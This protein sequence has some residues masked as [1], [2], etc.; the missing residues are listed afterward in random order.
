MGKMTKVIA[1][2]KIS[3]RSRD[4]YGEGASEKSDEEKKAE[5]E[6]DASAGG[7]MSSLDIMVR[8]A[9]EREA[10]KRESGGD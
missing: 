10:K 5:K 2:G 6:R 4:R 7:G 3:Q 8:R 1:G 9:Q